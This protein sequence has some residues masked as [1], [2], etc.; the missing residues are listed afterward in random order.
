MWSFDHHFYRFNTMPCYCLVVV[1]CV[2]ALIHSNC[3][4]NYLKSEKNWTW[5]IS[6]SNMTNGS[7]FKS[8]AM[9][10]M[11]KKERAFRGSEISPSE[12]YTRLN[13]W[14]TVLNYSFLIWYMAP[15]S[16]LW[17]YFYWKRSTQVEWFC[18]FQ[19]IIL[20]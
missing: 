14:R 13:S 3:H 4:T 1:A 7:I 19:E 17:D 9:P 15:S 16:F 8:K 2:A 10:D 11:Q 6:R 20:N 12:N 5:Y 18:L